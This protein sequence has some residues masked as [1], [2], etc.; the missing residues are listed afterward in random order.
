MTQ[1]QPTG[2][3]N[4]ARLSMGSKGLLVTGLLFLIALFLPWADVGSEVEAI[5]GIDIGDIPGAP[6]ASISG[7][8]ASPLFGWLGLLL[9]LGLLVWEGL[10][11]MGQN[12]AAGGR[13]PAFIS[14]ILGWAVAACGLIIFIVSLQAVAWGAFLGLLLSLAIAYAAYVRFQESKVGTAPPPPPAV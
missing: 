10:L 5:T 8:Q 11:A 4:W 9:T 14:A 7:L 12:I 3:F 2:G 6:D 13:S 1:P